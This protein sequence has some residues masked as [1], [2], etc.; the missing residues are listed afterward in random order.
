MIA[1]EEIYRARDNIGGYINRTPLI[2]AN[3]LSR[4][5][6][7][8]VYL[9]AENLQKTGSFKVRGAFHK[10]VTERPGRVIAASM[11]NH[12]QGVAYAAQS[13]GIGARIVMPVTSSIVKQEATRGYGADV[14]LHGESFQDAL[15]HAQSQE[16]F[17][18]IHAFDDRA[19][20]AGQGTAGL[21][22]LAD[23]ERPD[24]VIVP[25]GGGGL[26]A[27]VATAVKALSPETEVIGVQTVSATSARDSFHEGTVRD[28]QPQTTL[29]DGIAVGRVGALTL[30]V[31][32][33]VV[34]DILTVS[35][36]SIAVA[37]L[38][39]L[40]RK[41]LVVEGAGATPLALLLEQGGRFQG[42]QVVLLLSGG[43]IDFTL[44][45]RIIHRGLVSSGRITEFSVIV[46]DAPG[47]LHRLTGIIAS[48]NGNILNIIH[49]P[50]VRGIPIG[51]TLVDVTVETRGTQHGEEIRAALEEA[52]IRSA[53][54][55]HPATDS[56]Q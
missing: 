17:T 8:R 37:V 20:I 23:L 25:V 18:F 48:R 44:I 24:V 5:T 43:N 38:L 50:L 56:R 27:G 51:K 52:G 32:R 14:I 49:D 10:L 42:K 46:D 21:E 40:E 4:I 34:D 26:I 31:M 45:D 33:R 28:V 47:S 1:L 53:L 6:G 2:Y 7:A 41:K 3:S 54:P 15:D 55:H 30:D 29:A 13:L 22:I 9:K 39:L 11:G 16:G 19:I 12:A 35:E 36:E